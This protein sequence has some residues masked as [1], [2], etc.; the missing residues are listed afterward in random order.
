MNRGNRGGGEQICKTCW[1]EKFGTYRVCLGSGN[2]PQCVNKYIMYRHMFSLLRNGAFE[3]SQ[4]VL[5]SGARQSKRQRSRAENA[6]VGD[7]GVGGRWFGWS[8]PAPREGDWGQSG[9][10][11]VARAG[12]R[13]AS[14]LSAEPQ[15]ARV[16]SFPSRRRGLMEIRFSYKFG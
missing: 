1:S 13:G 9:G 5:L 6:G 10:G 11:G 15:C 4:I 7:R 8:V 16:C 3:Q 14:A 12:V 2:M